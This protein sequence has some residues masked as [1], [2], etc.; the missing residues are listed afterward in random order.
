MFSDP[1]LHG[2][3][4]LRVQPGVGEWGGERI[5]STR[6]KRAVR[7]AVPVVILLL[8]TAMFFLGLHFYDFVKG[9]EA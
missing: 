5:V 3:T 9:Y 2:R 7:I 6:I 4:P 8:L 1:D